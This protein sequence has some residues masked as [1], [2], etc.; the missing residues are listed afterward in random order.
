MRALL[1]QSWLPQLSHQPKCW[2][3]KSVH[4]DL[5]F[6]PPSYNRQSKPPGYQAI[7]ASPHSGQ[8]VRK[9]HILYFQQLPGCGCSALHKAACGDGLP[10]KAHFKELRTL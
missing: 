10:R 5:D 3:S 6:L 9:G 1:G 7:H 4:T 8:M 2:H